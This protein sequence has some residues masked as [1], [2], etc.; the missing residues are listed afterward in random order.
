M[1]TPAQREALI[2]LLHQDHY[3]PDELA[4]LLGVDLHLILQDA[5]CGRLKAYIVDHRVLDIRRE[6]VLAWFEQRSGR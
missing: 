3:T 4:R 6:D 1:V 2:D 5:Q